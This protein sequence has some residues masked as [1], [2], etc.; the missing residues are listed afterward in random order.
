MRISE[1]FHSI[2]GEGELTGVPSVFVRTSGCNLRC[3]WC[4]TPYTS[5]NPEGEEM[6]VE[7][8]AERVLAYS[9]SH[10]VLTGGEPMVA[11]GIHE[12]AAIL[13]DA[14][15]HITIE[16]AGTI[17]P[18]GIAC[19]LAS[20]S[21]KLAN[22]TPSME[23]AGAAWVERHEKL[24]LQPEI[25]RQWLDNYPYQ[26]KFVVSTPHELAEIERLLFFLD[27]PVHPCKVLI[28]PE[29]ITSE[30]LESRRGW[31]VDV[32]KLHGYRFCHR[33]HIDLFGNTR[34]T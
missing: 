21:P 24:R 26:L 17:A 13:K 9:C 33:L 22:S 12:L 8:I 10:V 4:D 7:A 1:I 3:S 15:K 28:M 2:Q 25:L 20:L 5:W 34:G 16:T 11:K 14:G 23:L 18:D 27:R 29:G 6:P 30:V 19:D 31:L 32:C